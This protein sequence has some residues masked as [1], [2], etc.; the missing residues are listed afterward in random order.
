MA[1]TMTTLDPTNIRGEREAAAARMRDRALT[2]YPAVCERLSGRGIDP[3]PLVGTAPDGGPLTVAGFYML[4]RGFAVTEKAGFAPTFQAARLA[5]DTPLP[6]RVRETMFLALNQQSSEEAAHGD[7][8]F[9]AVYFALGGVPA[10]LEDDDGLQENNFLQPT[11]DREMNLR[12][13]LDFEALLG[14]VETLA[15]TQAFPLVLDVCQRWQ[16]PLARELSRMVT[17]YVRPE[18]SRHVLAWR[19]LFRE[20]V[21]QRGDDA[22][23]R[24]YT[25][26]NWGRDRFLA[27]RMSRDEFHRHMQAATPTTEQLLGRPMPLS[28]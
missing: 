10:A 17:D 26:T 27:E 13:L 1:D 19:Y 15:L 21:A 18:E 8:I 24:Y 7:K 6:A 20:V 3:Q 16:H 5:L 23:E 25:M 4:M 22:I 9:G 11:G 14:G 12:I 28:A 2:Q